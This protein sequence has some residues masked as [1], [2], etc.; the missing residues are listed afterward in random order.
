MLPGAARYLAAN[1]DFA[2]TVHL[3][4]QP[5]E[6]GRGGAKAMLDEGL[7]DRFPRD[8]IYGLHNKPTIPAGRFAIR[9][10][11]ALA[12]A[13]SFA[14]VFHGTGGHGGSAPQ[15]ATDVTVVQADVPNPINPPSRCHVHARCPIAE[16]DPCST[17]VPE[18]RQARDGHWV[19]GHLGG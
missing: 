9:K 8:A 14:V 12:A 7:F 19:A 3:I 18:L 4:F 10:G 5:A 2:G 13:D 17:Q 16:S 1:R 15:T 6:E 11:P